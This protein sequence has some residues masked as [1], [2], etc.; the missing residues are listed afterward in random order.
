M[1]V[2]ANAT[3]TISDQLARVTTRLAHPVISHPLPKIGVLNHALHRQPVYIGQCNLKEA[4]RLKVTC[5]F[6]LAIQHPST[7]FQTP[8]VSRAKNRP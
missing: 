1:F 4:T 6:L 5:R 7:V 2:T 3:I 8:F